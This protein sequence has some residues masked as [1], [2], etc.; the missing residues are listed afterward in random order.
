MEYSISLGL[1]GRKSIAVFIQSTKVTYI[2]WSGKRNAP[3]SADICT[4]GEVIRVT[5]NHRASVCFPQEK[6]EG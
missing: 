2:G 3:T 4:I 5:V 1:A 6:K